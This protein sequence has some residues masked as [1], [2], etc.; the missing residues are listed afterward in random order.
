MPDLDRERLLGARRLHREVFSVEAG[1]VAFAP[2]RVNL[3]GDHT[4]Y[5]GG[6]VLPIAIDLGTTVAASRRDDNRIVVHSVHSNST[7]SEDLNALDP[8]TDNGWAAYVYGSYA[9]AV[10]RGW[11]TG[12][13]SLS[14]QG[15]LPLG[16]GLSS[17]AS[18]ECAVLVA[19]LGFN[20]YWVAG[21]ISKEDVA[22]AAQEAEHLF[23][24]VPCGIMDQSAS[25]RSLE[26]TALM[27][28]SRTLCAD[29]V[30]LCLEQ[31]GLAILLIDT[32]AHHEL[33]DGGYASRRSQCDDAANRLGVDVLAEASDDG[34]LASLP[35]PLNRR[36]RHVVSEHARVRATV[37]AFA[38]GDLGALGELFAASH[39]S[40][41]QDFEV[42]CLEL[43]IVAAAAPRAGAVGARMTGGGFGGSVVAIVRPADIDAIAAEVLRDLVSAGCAAP[44]FRLVQP[45]AGARLLSRP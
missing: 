26:G 4:D 11:F 30:D 13:V 12:G 7:V 3:M 28:D 2:G 5:N 8:L 44:T 39:A 17:S 45:G 22:L 14:I 32:N 6:L 40:L 37:S 38:T 24:H 33:N 43:D 41:S 42:S 35:D 20:H 31:N 29:H 19:L 16:A 10:R 27:L 23:A 25:M 18:L 9:A 36:A 34:A 21:D 15:D 1:A